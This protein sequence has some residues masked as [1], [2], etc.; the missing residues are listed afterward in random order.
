MDTLIKDYTDW[1]HAE[2][3]VFPAMGEWKQ[4]V[5]PF[6]KFN[7]DNIEVF[8]RTEMDGS[9]VYSDDQQTLRELEMAGLKLSKSRKAAINKVLFAYGVQLQ[10]EELTVTAPS[11]KR[12]NVLH[13]FLGAVKEVLDMHLLAQEKVKSFFMED[14]QDLFMAR[15]IPFIPNPSFYGKSG[16]TQTLDFAIPNIGRSPEKLIRGI[17]QPRKD[18]VLSA[19]MLIIDTL[20]VRPGST[21]MVILNDLNGFNG[22]L[23]Q[24]LRS[25]QMPYGKMSDQEGIIRQLKPAA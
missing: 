2:T 8:F 12:E 3:D 9:V 14:L 18:R 20:A 25:Y 16:L 4:I 10:G 11:D 17:S 21:G 5:T 23:E 7:N 19:I 6:L 15:G 24:A 22:D 13:R 1:L